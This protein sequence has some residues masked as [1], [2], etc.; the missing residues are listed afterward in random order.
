[1]IITPLPLS[2][3]GEAALTLARECGFAVFPLRAGSKVPLMNGGFYN[4][5]TDLD[6]VGRWWRKWPH[7]NIGIATGPVSGLLVVDLDPK[8]GSVAS[9]QELRREH[10]VF[11]LTR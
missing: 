11:P 9:E 10:K 5:T 3:L 2:T 4:A 8:N 1:M 6:Q 7:A